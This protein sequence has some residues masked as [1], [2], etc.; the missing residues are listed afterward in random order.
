[1]IIRATINVNGSRQCRLAVFL[2]F[3]GNSASAS[4]DWPTSSEFRS[5]KTFFGSGFGF[6]F[7]FWFFV[8]HFRFYYYF[9]FIFELFGVWRLALKVFVAVWLIF[10]IVFSA[11]IVASFCF[12]FMFD[13]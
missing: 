8:F 12:C 6:G 13:N 3:F 4:N 2:P 11:S 5:I 1:M 10:I 7:G 9:Y